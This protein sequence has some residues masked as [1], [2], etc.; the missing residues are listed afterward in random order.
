MNNGHKIAQPIWGTLGGM[1]PLTSAE[2]L[3]YIY[4]LS[5]GRTEQNM[6]RLY[7]MSDPTVPDRTKAL[8]GEYDNILRSLEYLMKRL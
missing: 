1:G 4:K 6:P 3:I 2:F 5:L 7:L 8:N